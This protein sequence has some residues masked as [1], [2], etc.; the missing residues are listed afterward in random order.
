MV[1]LYLY[2]GPLVSLLGFSTLYQDDSKYCWLLPNQSLK[3]TEIA[4]GDLAARQ[5]IF[6]KEKVMSAARI[7]SDDLAVCRHSLAPVR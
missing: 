2:Y 1:R 4:V 7:F 3:L 5:K 6:F